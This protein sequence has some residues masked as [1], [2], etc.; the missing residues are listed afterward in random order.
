MGSVL[1]V[2]AYGSV[3]SLIVTLVLYIT[4][5]S[6][7]MVYVTKCNLEREVFIFVFSIGWLVFGAT[8]FLQA[9]IGNAQ[10]VIPDSIHFFR[11]STELTISDL[12]L[13]S[14]RKLTE[15]SLAVLIWNLGYETL[16]IFGIKKEKYIASLINLLFVSTST[17][18]TMRI[19][20]IIVTE[21]EVNLKILKYLFL[22]SGTLHLA[23]FCHVRDGIIL[24]F[25][26]LLAYC[27]VL[28]L[29]KVKTISSIGNLFGCNVIITI[30]L[31]FLRNEL[32][33]VPAAFLV[34]AG[35]TYILDRLIGPSSLNVFNWAAVVI[36]LA[37][38][39]WFTMRGARPLYS[40]A[41]STYSDVGLHDHL[42]S[43]IW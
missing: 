13:P 1:T 21:R 35:F 15:G 28:F 41:F 20:I 4:T 43:S 42:G 3:A 14:L 25:L 31:V 40:A 6:F 16:S 22:T 12:S 30:A 39:S 27:W 36:A 23:V 29:S 17:I 32:I 38:V 26:S 33:F 7:I 5:T 18:F 8:S 9:V 2:P 11:L 34:A 37:L 19:G 24:F 10:L